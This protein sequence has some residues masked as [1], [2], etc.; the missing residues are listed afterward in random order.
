VEKLLT[1]KVL[2]NQILGEHDS[3]IVPRAVTPRIQMRKLLTLNKEG[4]LSLRAA[5]GAETEVQTKRRNVLLL[6]DTSGSMAGQKIEQAKSGAI[7]FAQSA[8]SKTYATALAVFA[9]RAAMVCDP[10]IDAAHFSSKIARVDIGLVGGTTDLAAGLT[11]ANKFRDLAAV[12][13]VTDGQ[14]ND[15]DAALEVGATLKTRAIDIICI[16]TDDADSDFLKRL[17]TR[18]DLATHVHSKNLRSAI[19]DASRFLPQG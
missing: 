18:S 6:I 3:P 19:T 8:L 10:T 1:L 15:N 5:D 2:K 4:K 16:G 12:V 9:D 11:L 17:A 7:D 14:S 13:V